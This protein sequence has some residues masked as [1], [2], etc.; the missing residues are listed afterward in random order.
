MVRTLLTEVDFLTVNNANT[1]LIDSNTSD[2]PWLFSDNTL[3]FT[4]NTANTSDNTRPFSIHLIP[5]SVHLGLY[6]FLYATFCLTYI[7]IYMSFDRKIKKKI[8]RVKSNYEIVKNWLFALIIWVFP[9]LFFWIKK[10]FFGE[11][12][13]IRVL[14]DGWVRKILFFV[15]ILRKILRKFSRKL[16]ILTLHVYGRHYESIET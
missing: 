12:W 14:W 11:K 5:S 7:Y 2:Y 10:V 4:V 3:P 15:Q 1:S 16:L 8:V 9:K 13:D 6:S